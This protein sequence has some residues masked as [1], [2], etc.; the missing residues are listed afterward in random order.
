[1]APLC[2]F[3]NNPEQTKQLRQAIDLK[4]S[5]LCPINTRHVLGVKT[6]HPC[7]ARWLGIWFLICSICQ[8]SW[9]KC[10]HGDQCQDTN[11]GYPLLSIWQL[12]TGTTLSGCLISRHHCWT[13][14]ATLRAG[15]NL[16]QLTVDMDRGCN[17][18]PNVQILSYRPYPHPLL[19]SGGRCLW[20]QTTANWI[21]TP[22]CN[23]CY[24]LTLILSPLCA[25]LLSGN[26]L[27]VFL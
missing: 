14:V 4:S 24:K 25:Y 8:C 20:N 19:S 11:S 3:M 27:T 10:S 12:D 13:A 17:A 21:Q 22:P 9:C 18:T 6:E 1:M 16:L 23:T 2:V 7:W 26:G 15:T 5:I